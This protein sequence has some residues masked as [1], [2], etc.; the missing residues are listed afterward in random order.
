MPQNQIE[1]FY[2]TLGRRGNLAISLLPKQLGSSNMVSMVVS[3]H[4]VG[5]MD[6]QFPD[7]CQITVK[8]L[9]N[10]INNNSSMAFR[11]SKQISEGSRFNVVKL[12][13]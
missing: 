5:W 10:R 8:S 11:I 1:P 13:K 6:S 9:I 4:T 12:T 3:F 7:Q 2:I